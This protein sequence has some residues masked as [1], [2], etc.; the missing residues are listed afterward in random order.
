MNDKPY[1]H[2]T[3][4][5]FFCRLRLRGSDES[6]ATF[7]FTCGVCIAFAYWR[8]KMRPGPPRPP[9]RLARTVNG[10]A[11]CN[12]TRKRRFFGTCET[13]TRSSCDAAGCTLAVGCRSIAD[14]NTRLPSSCPAPATRGLA[15]SRHSHGAV[16]G[17]TEG[18]SLGNRVTSQATN[19]Q[20]L[21]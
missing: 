6:R 4:L 20:Y 1:M 14:S 15:G 21:T 9:R 2:I 5:V 17:K 12:T 13:W 19:K 3:R 11:G 16:W 10:R 18:N 8:E 7:L